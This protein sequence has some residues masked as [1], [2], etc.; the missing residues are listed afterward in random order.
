MAATRRKSEERQR[1]AD[2]LAL[3]AAHY[4]MTQAA[5][6]RA[7]RAWDGSG[8]EPADAARLRA[9]RVELALSVADLAVDALEAEGLDLKAHGRKS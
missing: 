1:L 7:W 3:K 8:H 6:R 4:R 9:L 2:A 5:E